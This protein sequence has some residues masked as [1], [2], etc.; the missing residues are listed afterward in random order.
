M[1]EESLFFLSLFSS[2]CNVGRCFLSGGWNA[3][4]AG[5]HASSDLC[6]GMWIRFDLKGKREKD[7]KTTC[8]GT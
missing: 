7:Q 5:S 6:I 8:L 4:Q 2:I 3:F 1:A